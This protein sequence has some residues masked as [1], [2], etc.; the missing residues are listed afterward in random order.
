[1]DYEYLK[2]KDIQIGGRK[3]HVKKIEE[4]LVN[5]YTKEVKYLVNDDQYST[6]DVGLAIS[7]LKRKEKEEEYERMNFFQ[8]LLSNWGIFV[9]KYIFMNESRFGIPFG[10]RNYAGKPAAFYIEVNLGKFAWNLELVFKH[11][12]EYENGVM[13]FT[14]CPLKKVV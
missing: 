1:M 7:R 3:I 4:R 13:P 6:T 11:K 2:N 14:N 9:W 8:K 5:P 10:F 12:V